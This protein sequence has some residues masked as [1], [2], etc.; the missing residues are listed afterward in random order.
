VGDDAVW[1][2]GGDCYGPAAILPSRDEYDWELYQ[3]GIW[4]LM[5]S[6]FKSEGLL[7]FY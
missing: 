2:G 1:A 6:F 7:K 5:R 3:T 4:P